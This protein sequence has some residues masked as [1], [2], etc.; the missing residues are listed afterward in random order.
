M[1]LDIS[2]EAM[3]GRCTSELFRISQILFNAF[4]GLSLK[5][6][7]SHQSLSIS[8]SSWSSQ[9]TFWSFVLLAWF[10][11]TVEP[12][13]RDMSFM[14]WDVM[15]PFGFLQSRCSRHHCQVFPSHTRRSFP[16]CLSRNCNCSTVR[17]AVICLDVKSPLSQLSPQALITLRK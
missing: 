11:P 15:L 10:P 4:S 5:S 17:T 7:S 3:A 2:F 16:S 9:L 12:K 8:L 14:C 1:L 6:S 13:A